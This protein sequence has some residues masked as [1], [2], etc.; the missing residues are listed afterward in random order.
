[1][2]R[3]VHK[4]VVVIREVVALPRENR[5]QIVCVSKI[6]L[7]CCLHCSTDFLLNMVH[8]TIHHLQDLAG[9]QLAT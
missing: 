3:D 2:S 6:L 1:M 5:M 8:I 4:G 9:L 7:S